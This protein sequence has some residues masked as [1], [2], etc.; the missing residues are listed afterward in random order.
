MSAATAV[1][2]L[3]GDLAATANFLQS[4]TALPNYDSVREVQAKALCQRVKNL[5][6]VDAGAASALL[7]AWTAGKVWA[8][9]QTKEFSDLLAAAVARTNT[10]TAQGGK[11]AT[12]K[13]SA[14]EP[15]LSVKDIQALEAGDNIHVK[16]DVLACRCIKLKLSCPSES[17][18]RA[19]LA[20]GLSRAG[21]DVGA[22]DSYANKQLFKRLLKSKAKSLPKNC[23]H[24]EHYPASPDQL[25]AELLDAYSAEDHA[26][27]VQMQS[28]EKV[29]AASAAIVLRGSSKKIRG[30]MPMGAMGSAMQSWSGQ[31]ASSSNNS[32]PFN[33][34]GMPG[35]QQPGMTMMGMLNT[36]NTMM[37]KFM[38][39]QKQADPIPNMQYM[40]PG[41]SN[42]GAAA[43]GQHQAAPAGAQVVAAEVPAPATQLPAAA[44]QAPATVAATNQAAVQLEMSGGE[45]EDAEEEEVLR[46]ASLLANAVNKK[47]GINKKT[48]IVG[49]ALPKAKAKAQAKGKAKQSQG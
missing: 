32:M 33:M 8:T 9:E 19:I 43:S 3:K 28:P 11:R 1:D 18:C 15:Y 39:D 40:A 42:M 21:C 7:G 26:C 41:G 34:M 35:M 6:S 25:P 45:D 16:L 22:V 14:F 37:Q 36:M 29:Q 12:Q 30:N 46:Q 2:Q 27:T 31:A 44:T 13:V 4:M 10:G 20:A 23:F 49:K 24:L 38:Q 47:K 5:A 48:D 17:S